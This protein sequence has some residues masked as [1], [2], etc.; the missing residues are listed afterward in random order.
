MAVSGCTPPRLA[1]NP[2][3]SKSRTL[4]LT[5]VVAALAACGGAEA[6]NKGEQPAASAAVSAAPAASPASDEQVRR[7]DLAR[8]KGDTTAK[9]WMVIVSDFQCPF[10]KIWHDTTAATIEQEYVATGKIRVAYV[11]FPLRRHQF[12]MLSAE[13]AMC[14]GAQGKFWEF[15]DAL[16]AEQE[17]WSVLAD[18]APSFEAMAARL[19]LDVPAWKSCVSSHVMEPMIRA[20]LQRGSSAGV[21]ATP[22]FLIGD[23]KLEGAARAPAFRD[24][25][26]KALAAAGAGGAK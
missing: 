7:A 23:T 4:F 20:D 12:A 8:I 1:I 13:S 25:I 19:G 2:M 6:K 10:C 24:A 17:K 5:V 9:V 18:A 14:A 22:S 11:N 16:F 15:Q 3:T 26:D 21:N